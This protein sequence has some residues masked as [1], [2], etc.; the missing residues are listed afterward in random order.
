MLKRSIIAS[1][2]LHVAVITAA[3]L[4][5]VSALRAT[6]DE[7]PPFVPIERVT[8]AEKTDIAPTVQKE[9]P[10]PEAAPLAQVASLAPEL[11]T[12]LPEPV[13][14]APPEPEA[15]PEPPPPPPVQ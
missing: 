9:R 10:A 14:V 6:D 1:G 11:A 15:P 2:M 8:V 13:E 7:T 4:T 3:S 5:W 12:P